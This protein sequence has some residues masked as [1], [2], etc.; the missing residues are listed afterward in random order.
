MSLHLQSQFEE[1]NRILGGAKKVLIASHEN[2]DPDAVA[3]ILAL[4]IFLKRRGLETL[5]YLPTPPPKNLSFLPCFFEI[6]S[7]INSFDSDVFFCLDYSDFNRLKLPTRIIDEYSFGRNL[8]TIDHHLQGDQRGKVQV[9]EPDFS[10]TSEIIYLWLQYC[11]AKIDKDIATCL[12]TGIIADTGGFS[13]AYT[14]FR[15]LKVV[16]QL[17]LMGAPLTKIARRALTTQK[18]QA[19]SKIWGRALSRV[20]N[21]KKTGL[22]HSWVSLQDFKECG[23]VPSDLAGISSVIGTASQVNLTLFL[24]EYEPGKIKGSLRSEPFKGV[25]VANLAQS[26][27]G[28]GHPYAAGF[29]QEGTAEEVLKKVTKLIE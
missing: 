25:N 10:S 27:G 6:K 5:L 24:V 28:G 17:L 7:E 12:L 16:S 2:P 1:I 29:R 23:V 15:T 11:G 18:P 20:K 19:I 3:S 22:A 14:S 26:L 4:H 21:D 13:H 8:I 9:I